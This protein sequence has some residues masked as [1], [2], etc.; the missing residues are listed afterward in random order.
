LG[1]IMEMAG[2]QGTPAEEMPT[3]RGK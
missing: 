2:F 1:W 3:F